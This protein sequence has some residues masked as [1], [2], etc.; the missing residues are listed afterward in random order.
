M[1][2]L[3]VEEERSEKVVLFFTFLLT[4][5]IL[6]NIILSNQTTNRFSL[7]NTTYFDYVNPIGEVLH[8]VNL[9]DVIKSKPK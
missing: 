5:Y 8:H 2:L 6:C 9:A 7:V 4:K 1:I 3:V